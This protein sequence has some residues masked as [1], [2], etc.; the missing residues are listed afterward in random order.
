MGLM[1]TLAAA[2]RRACVGM[3]SVRA[4]RHDRLKWCVSRRPRRPRR[5]GLRQEALTET[6][7]YLPADEKREF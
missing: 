2:P 7:N 3:E 1:I 4:P 5:R 6:E